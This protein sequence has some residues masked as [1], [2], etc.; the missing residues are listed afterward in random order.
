MDQT[1]EQRVKAKE[2]MAIPGFEGLDPMTAEQ[3]DER[4]GCG[5]CNIR[6]HYAV[7]TEEQP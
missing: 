4:C 6:N 1:A 2:W 3:H 5:D 7:L